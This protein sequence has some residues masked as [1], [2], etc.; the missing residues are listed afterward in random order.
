MTQ[1][2]LSEEAVSDNVR[3]SV[4]TSMAHLPSLEHHWSQCRA[5]VFL[6]NLSRT[7]TH[8]LVRSP[9]SPF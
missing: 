2:P 8:I 6:I 9:V 7:S 3:V 4:H 5:A 1:V